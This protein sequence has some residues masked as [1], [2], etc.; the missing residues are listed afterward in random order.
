[1]SLIIRFSLDGADG[2]QTKRVG[3]LLGAQ[4]LATRAGTALYKGIVK[5]TDYPQLADNLAA[6]WEH[7]SLRDA[8]KLDHFWMYVERKKLSPKKKP[9]TKKL[10]K[11]SRN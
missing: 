3:K 7:L 10:P 1:M 6:F 4:Q 5:K 9:A 11:K 2:N 8:P